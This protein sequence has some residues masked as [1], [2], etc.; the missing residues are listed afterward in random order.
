MVNRLLTKD[1]IIEELR[2][3]DSSTG[4]YVED[5]SIIC[6]DSNREVK[7]TTTDLIMELDE[8]SERI[9][10]PLVRSNQSL[11][12]NAYRVPPPP[13]DVVSQITAA[14]GSVYGPFL[15]NAI[16]GQAIRA[17][18]RNL[19][20]PDNQKR[21]GDLPLDVREGLDYIAGKI[22]RIVTGDPEY[23]DNWDDIGGFAKIV[24][25]RIRRSKGL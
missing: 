5:L 23:L 6:K 25:D 10:I 16:V 2:R 7:Y 12:K 15:H 9:L 17:V 20:D 13:Q 8:F 1:E 24:A 3:L 19:P 14:R 21:W 22:S 18:M 11:P 4:Y